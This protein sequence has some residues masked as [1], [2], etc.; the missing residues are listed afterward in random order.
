MLSGECTEAENT[1][2]RD[3]DAVVHNCRRAAY[4]RV[5]AALCSTA[6]NTRSCAAQQRCKMHIDLPGCCVS[7]LPKHTHTP[8]G[9]EGCVS[10]NSEAYICSISPRCWRTYT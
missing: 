10:C 4:V 7:S 1:R 3:N 5:G 6:A 9:A 2:N 8:T